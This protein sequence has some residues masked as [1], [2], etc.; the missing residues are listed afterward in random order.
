[1]FIGTLFSMGMT[2]V[3]DLLPNSL[4]PLGNILAGVS[5]SIGSILGPLTGG[6][7]IKA[8]PHGGF[9]FGIAAIMFIV[10]ISCVPFRFGKNQQV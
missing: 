6:F 10:F 4:L 2:F 9:F 1:M 8:W 3:S 7:L 5:F